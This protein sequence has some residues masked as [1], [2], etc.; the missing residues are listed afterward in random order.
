ME[1]AAMSGFE[2]GTGYTRE[3]IHAALGGGTRGFL[4][5]AGGRVTGMCVTRE[6]NPGA[7]EV[8]L[9]DGKR[10][11]LER[12]RKHAATGAAVPLFIKRRRGDWEYVGDRLVRS[13]TEDPAALADLAAQAG[14]EG[15]ALA[16]FTEA[17]PPAP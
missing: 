13:F 17:G 9:I 15:I 7:P 12:A 10:D 11:A 6:K 4:L 2:K 8:I 5:T 16:F 1:T 3:Q 14:R